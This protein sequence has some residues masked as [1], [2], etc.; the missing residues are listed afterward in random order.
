MDLIMLVRVRDLGSVATQVL[1][2]SLTVMEVYLNLT[3]LATI[4]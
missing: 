2:V 1:R 4:A 3:S